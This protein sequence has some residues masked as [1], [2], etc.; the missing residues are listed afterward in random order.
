VTK[1]SDER[2]DVAGTLTIRGVAKAVTL[3]MTYLGEA[4]DPLATR[5]SASRPS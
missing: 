2:Y 4:K 3:P 1:R 5:A